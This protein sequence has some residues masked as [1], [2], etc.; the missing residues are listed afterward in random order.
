MQINVVLGEML[1][2]LRL[3]KLISD[4]I[5]VPIEKVTLG[6]DLVDDLG[7]DSLDVIELS[8]AV[9]D[10]FDFTSEITEDEQS[11]IYRVHDIAL[12][13]NKRTGLPLPPGM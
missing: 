5:C 13:I 7:C 9:E 3:Q 12:L 2:F 4:R 10:E 11:K 8:M 6:A 1:M